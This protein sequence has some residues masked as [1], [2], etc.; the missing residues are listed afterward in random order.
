M[1]YRFLAVLL[2]LSAA[3]SATPAEGPR[4]LL[5]VFAHP[6][7]E[8][9]V[10]PLLAAYARRGVRVQLAIVTDGEKGTQAHAAIPAGPELAKVRAEEARCSC[11]AL[12]IAPPI[13]LGFKDGELGK[14]SRPPWVPLAEVQAELAKLLARARP[15]AVI[16]FGPEGAYGHPDHRLVGA[17]VTQLVQAGADGAPARLFY[18]G[19][20][21]DRLPQREGGIPWSPTEPRFLTVRVPYETADLAASRAAL[22]CHKSQFRAEELEPLTQ[23]MAQVLGGRVYLRPWFGAAQADDVF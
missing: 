2:I 12:G 5:A 13:L 18:P 8:T 16:T 23:F 17:V 7:D 9:L 4:T 21:K 3:P 22:A 20:P 1:R 10:A 15:D 6:D 19:L 11:R 14:Q